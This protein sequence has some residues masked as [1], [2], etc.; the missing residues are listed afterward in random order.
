MLC[1]LLRSFLAHQGTGTAPGYSAL[2]CLSKS[3]GATKE[4]IVLHQGVELLFLE[5][6]LF[7]SYG[8]EFTGK[9]RI[10]LDYIKDFQVLTADEISV[11]AEGSSVHWP[12]DGCGGSVHGYGHC[13]PEEHA[14]AETGSN[15]LHCGWCTGWKA[16]IQ[17]SLKTTILEA[18]DIFHSSGLNLSGTNHLLEDSHILQKLKEINMSV[19]S[20]HALN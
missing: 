10:A 13:T 19:H 4:R 2:Y 14:D 11:S 9:I 8:W 5:I 6:L 1:V 12:V 20:L 3:L 15:S 17:L 7:K 16:H 18:E